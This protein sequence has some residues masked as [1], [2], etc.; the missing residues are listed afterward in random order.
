MALD[1]SRQ[2]AEAAPGHDEIVRHIQLYIDS[3]NEPS[4]EKLRRFF[5]EQARVTCTCADG[6]LCLN[7]PMERYFADW[8]SEAA[9]YVH[10]ILDV[11][12]AGDV[13][14]VLLEMHIDGDPGEAWVDTHS[15]L[16]LDGLWKSMNKT[17]THASRASWA[18][19]GEP[20]PGEAPDRDQIVQFIETGY[21]NAFHEADFSKLRRLFHKDSWYFFTTRDGTLYSGAFDDD[22]V[23]GWAGSEQDWEHTILSVTQAGD[24]AS[25]M[26]EMRSM[27]DPGSAWVDIHA[28]LRIDGEWYDMNKTATHASRAAW[29]AP[30]AQTTT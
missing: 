2:A 15:L 29:A 20:A 3:Q 11:T 1:Q 16:R 28:L 21:I 7:D 17:A 12:Q 25:V 8:T 4:E 13:A 9:G 10:T 27:S 6:D 26:L 24:V 14:S 23:R 30:L 19:V 5:H 18:G 22:E